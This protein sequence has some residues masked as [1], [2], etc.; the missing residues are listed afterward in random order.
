MIVKIRKVSYFHPLAGT[1]YR[2][3]IRFL[4]IWW[5][6]PLVYP[7]KDMCCQMMRLAEEENL[8]ER[9]LKKIENE[10]FIKL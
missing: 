7:K 10:K 3:Q 9:P 4:F 6:L 8:F 1:W 5:T 2:L